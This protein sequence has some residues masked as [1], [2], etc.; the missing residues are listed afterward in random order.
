LPNKLPIK[1]NAP[2]AA[3]GIDMVD[4]FKS[5]DFEAT[6]L[7]RANASGIAVVECTQPEPLKIDFIDACVA[8]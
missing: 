8:T 4:T 3:R 1:L 2:L 5:S 7:G 6:R